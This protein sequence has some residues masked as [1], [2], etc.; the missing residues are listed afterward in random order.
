MDEIKLLNILKEELQ[1]I[2]KYSI[3]MKE[4]I[5][6]SAL[7]T[8]KEEVLESVTEAVEN[9][10]YKIEQSNKKGGTK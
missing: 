10:I 1:E 2:T 4:G 3:K 5:T 7:E 8:A 6:E 9:T